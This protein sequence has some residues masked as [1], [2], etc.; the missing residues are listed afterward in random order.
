LEGKKKKRRKK[1]SQVE[2]WARFFSAQR[3]RNGP[4]WKVV[5]ALLFDTCVWRALLIKIK[6]EI[7][8]KTLE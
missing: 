1:E 4:P 3:Q 8:K 2:D 5:I 7:E 6:F